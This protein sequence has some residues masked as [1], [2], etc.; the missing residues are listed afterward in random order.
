HVYSS[1]YS[2]K[3]PRAQEILGEE[4]KVHTAEHIASAMFWLGVPRAEI[5]RARLF[6]EPGERR[7]P[8]A[9]LH[10][11]AATDEKTWPAG[12]FV[13]VADRLSSKSG[14]DPVFLAGPSDDPAVF[15]RFEVHRNAPIAKIK[16][17]LAGAQIF[18]GNDSGPA[19]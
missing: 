11:F 2:E 6:A 1:V 16:S 10:P 12:R 15:A 13:E 9:V 7:A 8:Y 14:L 5:P 17:L 19:H 18:I 4:R 3:I